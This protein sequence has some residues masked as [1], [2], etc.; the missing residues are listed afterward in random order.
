MLSSESHD[1]ADPD[2]EDA[3]GFAAKLTVGA[4]NVFRYTVSHHN[5]DDGWDL[6]AKPDTGPISPVTIEDSLSYSNGTLTNGTVNPSG[7]RN[8]FKLGGSD[9]KVNHI[10]RRSV[11]YNNG[12]HGFTYN[13]NPGSMTITSNVSVSN[14]ERNYAFDEGTSTFRSNTS[15]RFGVSAVNDKITGS[16]D[17]SNQ[18]WSGANGSRCSTLSG[19]LTWSFALDGKLVTAFGGKTVT[20]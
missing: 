2:G 20:F 4:G 8:G 11:A 10:V 9:I 5:I 3:D 19:A 18:F 16:S 1:N 15:C 17:S 13:S 14:A 6:F 7:D 12:H